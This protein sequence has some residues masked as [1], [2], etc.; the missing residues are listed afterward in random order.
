M[1]SEVLHNNVEATFITVETASFYGVKQKPSRVLVNSQ[2][3]AF[4][5][6]E[7]QVSSGLRAAQTHACCVRNC[8]F[9]RN[10]ALN[11]VSIL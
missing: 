9:H 3:A 11:H 1:T 6:R 5:Y 2:D 8:S 10:S 7:N 4:T